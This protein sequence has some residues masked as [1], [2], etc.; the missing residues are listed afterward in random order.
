MKYTFTGYAASGCH[1][2]IFNELGD[3]IS[4]GLYMASCL[5]TAL[6]DDISSGIEIGTFNNAFDNNIA[7]RLYGEIGGNNAFNLDTALI[8]NISR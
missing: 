2:G 3:N 5:C 8:I 4:S 6:K 7:A 1:C